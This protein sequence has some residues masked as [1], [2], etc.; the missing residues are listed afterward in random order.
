MNH[1]QVLET[2]TMLARS[3]GSYGRMLE[4]ITAEGLDYLAEQN[5]ADPID[6]IMFL[7]G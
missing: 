7:E 6:L 2:L 5:F 4:S 3:Q 1:Q